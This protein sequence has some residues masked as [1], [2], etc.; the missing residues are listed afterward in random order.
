VAERR[1]VFGVLI[2]ALL[3]LFGLLAAVAWLP[4]RQA[5]AKWR[6]GKTDEAI[7]HAQEWSRLKLW[8]SQYH[9]L[10]AAAHLSAGR[11]ADAQRYLDLLE[12]GWLWIP[13]ITKDEVA[14][15]LFA[16]GAYRDFLAYDAASRER[17]ESD[18]APLYRAAA[19]ALDGR[20]AEAEAAIRRIDR[21]DVDRDKLAALTAAIEDRKRGTWPFVIDRNGATVAT[22]NGDVVA[23]DRNFAALIEKEAGPLTIESNLRRLGIHDT[24]E[25]SLDRRIQAA[26]MRALSG[27]RGSLVAIDPKTNEVVAIASSRGAG[28]L[29]NLA[30]EEQYE[31]GSVIKVLT[32]ATGARVDFPY[33]CTGALPIDGRSFGDWREGGHGTLADLDEAMAQSCNVVFADIGLEAG[34]E[35]LVQLHKAAGFDKNTNLGLFEVPNGRTVGELFNNFEI[36]FYAIGLEHETT[37]TFHLATLASMMANRG[38]LTTPRIFRARRSILGEVGSAPPKQSTVQVMPRERAEEV[39]ALMRAVVERPQGTG[40]RAKV[41]G[42]SLALKTGTAGEEAGGFDSLIIAFAPVEEPKIAFALIAED[43]GPAEFGATKIAHDFL[44]AI[45][46]N[47]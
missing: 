32:A 4:L 15:R 25:L 41:E 1:R 22:Y 21:G 14:K 9:Q 36:A 35:K 2:A 23:V 5:R 3:V 33:T 7:Q 28:P 8:R 26:A 34:R 11:R 42:M 31:P 45:A 44:S 20:I 29:R 19:L 24:I 46:G 38:A 30:L 10:L 16:R 6:A 39:I 47:L 43:A 27:F 40:R 12:R 17:Y 37:T 13:L 18:E